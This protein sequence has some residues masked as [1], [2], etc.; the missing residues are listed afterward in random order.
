VSVEVSLDYGLTFPL[1]HS[2][3]TV[4]DH[5]HDTLAQRDREV[6]LIA[7]EKLGLDH[8][9]FITALH[10]GICQMESSLL[11][12]GVELC[13]ALVLSLVCLCWALGCS[14]LATYRTSGNLHLSL[15]S[16]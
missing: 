11:Q 6:A 3:D 13:H 16:I 5:F 9:S 4:F 1:T 8:Y 12:N 15:F 10:Q 2:C 14:T 7:V